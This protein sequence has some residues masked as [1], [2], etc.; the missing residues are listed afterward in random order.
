M[1]HS[2]RRASRVR[3]PLRGRSATVLPRGQARSYSPAAVRQQ[4]PVPSG[5][6]WQ[7]PRQTLPSNRPGWQEPHKEVPNKYPDWQ[8]PHTSATDEIHPILPKLY[9]LWPVLFE[10]LDQPWK[11]LAAL[12]VVILL[13]IG[14]GSL[15]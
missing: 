9:K 1:N 2:P 4:S 11:W 13:S 6:S 5:S 12:A 7:N 14:I 8:E 15:L 10:V 3:P